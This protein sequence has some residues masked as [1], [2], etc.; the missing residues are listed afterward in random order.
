[1]DPLVIVA[2]L[3]KTLG[4]LEEKKGGLVRKGRP[5]LTKKGWK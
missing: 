3:Q 2:K 1:M 5:R 4:R